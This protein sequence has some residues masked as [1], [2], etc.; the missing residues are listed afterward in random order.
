MKEKPVLATLLLK[1]ST[2]MLKTL[3]HSENKDGAYSSNHRA[4]SS[5]NRCFREKALP[6]L[7]KQCPSKCFKNPPKHPQRHR[8]T[9]DGYTLGRRSPTISL[10]PYLGRSIFREIT[11]KQ[12]STHSLVICASAKSLR[13]EAPAYTENPFSKSSCL[14]CAANAPRP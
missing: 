2:L 10:N 7:D 14:T 8:T 13:K 4:S 9:T 12:R 3:R 1:A 11:D 5:S 6:E